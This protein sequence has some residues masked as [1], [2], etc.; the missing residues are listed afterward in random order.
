MKILLLGFLPFFGTMFAAP[1]SSSI[2]RLNRRGTQRYN[3][4]ADTST[5]GTPPPEDTQCRDWLN[6]Y[7][8]RDS[9]PREPLESD[10]YSAPASPPDWIP[11]ILVDVPRKPTISAY[12]STEGSGLQIVRPPPHNSYFTS[13]TARFRV[14]E[15]R[16]TP[17]RMHDEEPVELVHVGLAGDDNAPFQLTINLGLKVSDRG[18][19]YVWSI[20]PNVAP[21]NIED[22]SLTTNIGDDITV[23]VMTT[24]EGLCTISVENHTRGNGIRLEG[25]QSPHPARQAQRV[26]WGIGSI[27]MAAVSPPGFPRLAL[28]ELSALTDGRISVKPGD[29]DI[30]ILTLQSSDDLPVGTSLE[31]GNKLIVQ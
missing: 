10:L 29:C 25:I 24:L 3:I 30:S 2:G 5:L 8:F 13:A 23:H 31:G 22:N 26:V 15:M 14:P 20:D 4:R 21:Q 27:I 1:G 6:E 11:D 17:E 28:T 18:M 12:S 9:P 16:L 19:Q 7:L